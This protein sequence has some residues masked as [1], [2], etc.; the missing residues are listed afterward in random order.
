MMNRVCCSRRDTENQNLT[1][2]MP[3]R[4]SIRSSSGACRMN[5]RYSARLQYPITR[6]TPARLY[7]DRSN[8]TTSPAAGRCAMYRWKYH[9]LFSRSLGFSSATTRA[10]R[11]LR[12]SMNRLMVP[13]L[14]A[15]SRPSKSTI[16]RSPVSL[17]QFCSL[18]SSICI[19]RFSRS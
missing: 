9:W 8:S 6:S 4:T 18:S 17:I 5:S 14:P 12:C 16:S 1:R 3:E 10:P 15:A 19:S 7:Q 13:P 2:W 11:G